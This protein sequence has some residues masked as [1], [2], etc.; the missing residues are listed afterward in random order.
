MA[1]PVFNELLKEAGLSKRKLA[2]IL[3]VAPY[4]VSRWKEDVPKYAIGYLKLRI[5]IRTALKGLEG[6]L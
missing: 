3:G 4:T 6:I 1:K 2:L 5:A